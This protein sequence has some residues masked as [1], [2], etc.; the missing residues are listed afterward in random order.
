VTEVTRTIGWSSAP[1][2]EVNDMVAT[3]SGVVVVVDSNTPAL[4]TW[5]PETG[6]VQELAREGD[7]PGEVRNPYQVAQRPNGGVAVYDLKRAAI[8]LYSASL[9]YEDMFQ[10]GLISNPKDFIVLA[11]GSFVIAGGRISNP[12]HLYRFAAD[13]RELEAWGD[14]S[15]DVGPIAQVHVAGGALRRGPDGAWFFGFAAP[16]QILRFPGPRLADPDVVARDD[17]LLP[18]P[19]QE[20]LVKETD[21][22][23]TA[24]LW[25]HDRTTGI[26]PID[27]DQLMTV[28]TRFYTGDSVWTIHAA[29]GSVTARSEV[30]RAYYLFGRLDDSRVLG[31]Y[32]DPETDEHVAVVLEVSTAG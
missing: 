11:D 1:F 24:F 2:T 27:R 18:P 5:N 16:Y 20:G 9:E 26:V 6:A 21:F 30:P 8:L 22:G 32:R 13:G 10:V 12:R 7:G 4:W 29:D 15:P 23:A 3:A 19:T 14:A 31:S 17:G 25:W 28:V